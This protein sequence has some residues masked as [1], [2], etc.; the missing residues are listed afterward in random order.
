MLD[1]YSNW[2]LSSERANAARRELL[3][4]GMN[5]TKF[6]RCAASPTRCRSIRT[7][8]RIRPTGASASSVLNAQAEENFLRD[9]Q[10]PSIDVKALPQPRERLRRPPP[11]A[12]RSKDRTSA[13]EVGKLRFVNIMR[14]H[15]IAALAALALVA[16]LPRR[17]RT[18]VHHTPISRSRPPTR[19]FTAASPASTARTVSRFA[20]NKGTSTTFNCTKERSSIR[21]AS[22]WRPGWWSASWATTPART[23][24]PT[25]ST[26]RTRSMPA[27]RTTAVG[28][29][30]TTARDQP[31]LF[32]R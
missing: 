4:G 25:R 15:L 27:C 9:G 30:T 19:R 31:W 14:K 21:P 10:Q 26:R 28:P 3:A 5:P 17:P 11:R 16:P 24:P 22:R 6:Y 29:G 18:R 7:T 20:T 23:L 8:R 12:R 2:E 1:G 32:L 13:R